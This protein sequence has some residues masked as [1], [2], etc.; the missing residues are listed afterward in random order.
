[1]T[2]NKSLQSNDAEAII[3]RK[4]RQEEI[5]SNPLLE[6][7]TLVIESN[8]EYA[9]GVTT[10]L[11]S[12][13]EREL[14][15]NEIKKE[16]LSIRKTVEKNNEDIIRFNTQILLVLDKLRAFDQELADALGEKLKPLYIA[17]DLQDSGAQYNPTDK[18]VIALKNVLTSKVSLMIIGVIIW[19]LLKLLMKSSGLWVL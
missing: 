13:L 16:V 3:L 17:A 11:D 12:D 19:V 2:E 10:I 18:L 1:M 6:A 15:L 5:D 4:S 9:R 8:A 14:L 7:L